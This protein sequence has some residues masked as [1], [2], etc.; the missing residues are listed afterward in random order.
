MDVRDDERLAQHLDH[1][2]RG[3]DA[4]LEPELHARRRGG[5]E[6]LRPAPRDE[7]LVRGDDVLAAAEQELEH[8]GA[9]RVE[10]AH[11]LGDD[12]DRRVVRD[13]ARCRW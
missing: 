3:A 12:G 10:A 6:E 11:H 9:G 7:L 4:R 8:V 5:G 2:D 1:R 13:L